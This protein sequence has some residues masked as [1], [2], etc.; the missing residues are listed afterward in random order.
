[1]GLYRRGKIFWFSFMFEGKR[2]RTSLNSDKKRVAEKRAA[3]LTL[4]MVEGK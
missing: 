3:K 2:I 1:M 4:D